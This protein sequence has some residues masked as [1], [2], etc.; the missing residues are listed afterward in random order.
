MKTVLLIVLALLCAVSLSAKQYLPNYEIVLQSV[1]ENLERSSRLK[2]L[3]PHSI[4]VWAETFVVKKRTSELLYLQGLIL[5]WKGSYLKDL[6]A[7]LFKKE[8]NKTLFALEENLMSD[9]VW[10]EKEQKITFKFR[11]PVKLNP[12]NHFCLV[13]TIQKD[14]Q[15][16]LKQGKF[17]VDP[18]SFPE[19]LKKDIPQK[20]SFDIR[21]MLQPL[22]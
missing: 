9:G 3:F 14:M 18:T 4:W 2:K 5:L 10:N 6:Q 21:S 8:P 11:H 22:G 15:E 13:L 16:I 12:T 20:L 17:S 7:S 1:G 19:Q